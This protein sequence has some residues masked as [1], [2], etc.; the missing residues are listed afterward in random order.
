MIGT[1]GSKSL[2]WLIA[3][4]GYNHGIWDETD[5]TS[6]RLTVRYFELIFQMHVHHE[7]NHLAIHLFQ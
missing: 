7:S 1:T 6:R 3:Y 2:N 4:I 5:Y